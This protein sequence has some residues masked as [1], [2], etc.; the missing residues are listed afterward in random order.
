MN[1]LRNMSDGEFFFFCV[2][3]VRPSALIAMKWIGS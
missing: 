1:W 2:V 3:V